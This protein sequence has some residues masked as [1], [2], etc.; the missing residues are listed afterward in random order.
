MRLF[1][2]IAFLFTCLSARAEI[3]CVTNVALVAACGSFVVE[4]GTNSI[5]AI[6]SLPVSGT[7]CEDGYMVTFTCSCSSSD[8]TCAVLSWTC[9]GLCGSGGSHAITMPAGAQTITYAFFFG[10]GCSVASCEVF[11]MGCPPPPRD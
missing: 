11:R 2:V 8:Q 1:A 3:P 4:G 5:T 6:A 10:D 7:T 9:N